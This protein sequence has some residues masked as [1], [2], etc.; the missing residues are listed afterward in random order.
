MTAASAPA[1]GI[2]ANTA[3]ASAARYSQLSR[4]VAGGVL[5]RPAHRAGADLDAQHALEVRR[6]RQPQ[7]AAAAVGVDQEARAAGLR[8]RGDVSD[9]PREQERVVLEKVARQEPQ[10]SGRRPV[11]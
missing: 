10:A 7:Q 4:A 6:R 3:L 8:L 1:N 11:R 2:A 5:A 9:Q